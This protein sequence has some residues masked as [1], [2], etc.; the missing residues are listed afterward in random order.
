MNI[1]KLCLAT[2]LVATP[3][4]VV[5]PAAQAGTGSSQINLGC[6]LQSASGEPATADCDPP[7]IPA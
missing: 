5:A 1:R 2:L 4:L 6:L 3:L 7:S